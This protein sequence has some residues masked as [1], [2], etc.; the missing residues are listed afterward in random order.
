MSP[1]DNSS[2]TTNTTCST[3]TASGSDDMVSSST[4]STEIVPLDRASL[5]KEYA[6]DIARID[7]DGPSSS[8]EKLAYYR[9]TKYDV[10]QATSRLGVSSRSAKRPD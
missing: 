6:E 8:D 5:I 3:E 7:V 1:H 10:D 9:A 2:S 4:T